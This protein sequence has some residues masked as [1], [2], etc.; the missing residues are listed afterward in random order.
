MKTRPAE[1]GHPEILAAAPLQ[2][3][4]SAQVARSWQSLGDRRHI[5]GYVRA[6]TMDSSHT[7]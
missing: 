7:K 1:P 4:R 5:G 6:S 3:S 2:N